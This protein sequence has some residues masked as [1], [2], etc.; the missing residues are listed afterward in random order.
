MVAGVWEEKGHVAPQDDN[1]RA[2]AWVVPV[3]QA[4]GYYEC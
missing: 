3:R 2:V 4:P 1:P